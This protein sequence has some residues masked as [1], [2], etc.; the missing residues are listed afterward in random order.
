MP[1][2]IEISIA[3]SDEEENSNHHYIPKKERKSKS[4]QN[5]TIS[6]SPFIM[7]VLLYYPLAVCKYRMGNESMSLL[8]RY[9]CY[10][11]FFKIITQGSVCQPPISAA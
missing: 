1:I 7:W 11:Q 5:S 8:L 10:F 3:P 2:Q 4:V 9:R 6:L